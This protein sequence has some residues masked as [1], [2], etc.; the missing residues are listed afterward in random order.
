[1]TTA[2]LAEGIALKSWYGIMPFLAQGV[3][4]HL[5]G[6]LF[7]WFT[8]KAYPLTNKLWLT[9][10]AIFDTYFLTYYGMRVVLGWGLIIDELPTIP[11]TRWKCIII[12]SSSLI[13]FHASSLLLF[14]L[15]VEKAICVTLPLK[16]NRFVGKWK[17]IIGITIIVTYVFVYSFLFGYISVRGEQKYLNTVYCTY[18]YS[19]MLGYE[20]LVNKV[21]VS[22]LHVLSTSVV[23]NS[24]YRATRKRAVMTSS[25]KQSK[26]MS[27]G[28][29]TVCIMLIF[30]NVISVTFTMPFM[31]YLIIGTYN[32][33]LVPDNYTNLFVRMFS[34]ELTWVPP[35]LNWIFIYT[36]NRKFREKIVLIFQCASN[37]SQMSAHSTEVRRRDLEGN[38]V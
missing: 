7:T 26:S 5:V 31:F 4:G 27:S 16:K 25:T 34:T 3:F 23:V 19:S 24:L 33:N 13:G 12:E 2:Q 20:L 8:D 29:K 28:E 38:H 21:I 18:D 9:F 6:L 1:M 35:A 10:I 15:T 36:S 17:T 11:E 22:L 30:M 14:G 37:I 32:T